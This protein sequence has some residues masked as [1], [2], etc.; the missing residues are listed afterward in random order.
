MMKRLKSKTITLKQKKDDK[1]VL[2]F[3]FSE[4]PILAI[5]TMPKAPFICLE[6]WFNSADKVIET[7]YFKDKEGIMNLKPK[8]K[9]KCKFS[10]K[11]F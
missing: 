11:F 7:G 9:F 2:E 6:P 5:W 1:K 3:D 4:F 10:V 8:Q